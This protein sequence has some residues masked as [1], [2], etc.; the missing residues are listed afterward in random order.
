[1]RS[2]LVLL[3][4]VV[5]VKAFPCDEL[6][7]TGI[8]PENNQYIP[9][10]SARANDMDEEKFDEAVKVATLEIEIRKAAGDY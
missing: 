6:G 3:F 4:M 9:V 1:M 8:A 2:I 10:R 5:A 7:I